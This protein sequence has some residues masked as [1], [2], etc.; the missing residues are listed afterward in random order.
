MNSA[1]T[2]RQNLTMMCMLSFCRTASGWM[3]LRAS[4]IAHSSTLQHACQC[5]GVLQQYA[6]VRPVVYNSSVS[7]RG[8]IGPAP[9]PGRRPRGRVCRRHIIQ[10]LAVCPAEVVE[11][12]PPHAAGPC[13]VN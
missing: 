13:M 4:C 12:L 7:H 6:I 8:D 9:V 5:C 10:R 2:S 3:L 11:V 1:L